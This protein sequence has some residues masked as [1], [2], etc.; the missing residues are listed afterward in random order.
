MLKYMLK[1]IMRTPVRSIAILLFFTVFFTGVLITYSIAIEADNGM[2]DIRIDMGNRVKLEVDIEKYISDYVA[3]QNGNTGTAPVMKKLEWDMANRISKSD[4]V[5]DYNITIEG[6]G[7]ADIEPVKFETTEETTEGN[8]DFRLIGDMSLK[9]NSDFHY[10]EKKLVEGRVYTQDEVESRAAVAIIDR[11]L[12]EI[13]QLNIGDIVTITSIEKIEMAF[14]IIGF[15]EDTVED[16]DTLHMTYMVRANCLYIPYTTAIDSRGNTSYKDMITEMAFFVKDP[17]KI[18]DFRTTVYRNNLQLNGY[19]LN[20]D[21]AI[22]QKRILPLI[23]TKQ[24]AMQ[25]ANVVLFIG[26]F[27][28]VILIVFTAYRKKYDVLKLKAMGLKSTV[29]FKNILTELSS[30]IIISLLLSMVISTVATPIMANKIITITK[31]TVLKVIAASEQNAMENTYMGGGI[32]QSLN[33]EPE[34]S[35]QAGITFETLLMILAVTAALLALNYVL[36]RKTAMESN[37]MVAVKKE[38]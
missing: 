14:E 3:F 15:Y 25:P 29:I 35:I 26:G 5:E 13:N 37:P 17:L 31:P 1:N 32:L 6:A 11:R 27:L 33:I 18:D 24:L 7:I 16:S 20:A 8:P 4:Y 2:D 9:R 21:D 19:L 28:S 12:A 30:M 38:G 22:Y 36:C 34:F 10:G 23:Y